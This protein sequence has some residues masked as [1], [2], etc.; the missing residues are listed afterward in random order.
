[1]AIDGFS[2]TAVSNAQ[3]DPDS[4][5]DTT[6]ITAF[7][8]SLEVLNRWMGKDFVAG[9]IANHDH[10]MVNSAGVAGAT[11]GVNIAIQT[12]TAPTDTVVEVQPFGGYEFEPDMVITWG[13]ADG[14]SQILIKKNGQTDSTDLNDG[15]AEL[16]EIDDMRHGGIILA[17]ASFLKTAGNVFQVLAL[18]DLANIIK[19]GQYTGD[20][21]AGGQDIT[22]IGFQPEVVITWPDADGVVDE[23]AHIRTIG[24]AA[25]ASRTFENSGRYDASNHIETFLA[26]GFHV[27][28]DD[29]VNDINDLFN[30]LCLKTGALNGERVDVRTYIGNSV[31]DTQPFTLTFSPDL[32][33][34]IRTDSGS[35]E[36]QFKT[37]AMGTFSYDMSNGFVRSSGIKELT[38]D[39][40]ILGTIVEVNNSLTNYVAIS[41]KGGTFWQD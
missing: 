17:A 25:N 7:R 31:D 4:P 35:S 6:I 32:V 29:S 24:F 13:I 14:S 33:I 8:D 27:G 1:M 26:D 34:I 19:V 36:I 16:S 38:K 30:F 23:E 5:L 10:D 12:Y 20:N 9:Q 22:G 21:N 15:Q 11:G 18:K 39:G 37:R 28:N 40:M 41:I 2:F 3:V